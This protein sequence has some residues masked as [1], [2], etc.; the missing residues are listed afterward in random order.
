MALQY[1]KENRMFGD[2]ENSNKRIYRESEAHAKIEH[3][4]AYMRE[5]FGFEKQLYEET[6]DPNQ[7]Y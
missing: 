4:K 2:M 3:D 5:D 1:P 6:H 7:T